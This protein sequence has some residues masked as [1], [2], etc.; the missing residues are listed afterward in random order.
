MEKSIHDLSVAS[1]VHVNDI[2]EFINAQIQVNKISEWEI[3]NLKIQL[4]DV[5][6]NNGME[7]Q[8]GSGFCG[9]PARFYQ[10]RAI[11]SA[12]TVEVEEID[13]V[14]RPSK[15]ILN[16]FIGKTQAKRFDGNKIPALD[17]VK[18]NPLTRF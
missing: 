6:E 16:K 9:R 5:F 18:I 17:A 3:E 2:T 8:K 7:G 4:G 15:P 14:H 11:K 1:K 12:N 13:A 10:V